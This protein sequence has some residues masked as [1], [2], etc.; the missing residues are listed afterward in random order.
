MTTLVEAVLREGCVLEDRRHH[1]DVKVSLAYA[2]DRPEHQE[3]HPEVEATAKGCKTTWVI[4]FSGAGE[5]LL[6]QGHHYASAAC[7]EHHACHLYDT[8]LSE[9]T[10]LAR[11]LVTGLL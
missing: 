2:H 7:H 10:G 4:G 6:L 8:S 3:P 5:R 1:G 11:S 9:L